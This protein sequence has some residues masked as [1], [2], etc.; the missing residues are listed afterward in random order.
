MQGISVVGLGVYRHVAATMDLT[1]QNTPY[2]MAAILDLNSEPGAFTYTPH[3]LGVVLHAL[4]PRPQ[5]F[6]T[7]AAISSEMTR[8]S[9]EVWNSYVKNLEVENTLVINVSIYLKI[10]ISDVVHKSLASRRAAC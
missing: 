5:V 6:I 3:N 10:Q 9:I 4:L 8:E 1:F 2:C 7:G